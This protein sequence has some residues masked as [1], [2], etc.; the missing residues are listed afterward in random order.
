MIYGGWWAFMIIFFLVQKNLDS[1]DLRDFIHNTI[2]LTIE[3][4]EVSLCIWK[5]IIDNFVTNLLTGTCKSIGYIII[6][7][8][9]R[10]E[11][12]DFT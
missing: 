1:D 8:I 9:S 5:L 12:R 3:N 2:F 11:V 10:I 7:F 6:S 4:S